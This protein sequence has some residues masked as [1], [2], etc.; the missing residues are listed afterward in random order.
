MKRTI[1]KSAI[2]GRIISAAAA[3]RHP[4]TSY[5]LTVKTGK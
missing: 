4:K 1:Y 3:K 2:S 5:A